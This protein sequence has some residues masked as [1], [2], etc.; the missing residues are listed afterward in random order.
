M[1][2]ILIVDDDESIRMLLSQF[3]KGNG[4]TCEEVENG[5]RA[6]E[7]VLTHE[8]ELVITD[9][10]MP[11]M[12]GIEFLKSL[13]LPSSSHTHPPPVIF[14]TGNWSETL[15]NEA[16]QAGAKAVILKPYDTKELLMAVRTALD[17]KVKIQKHYAS[18]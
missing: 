5:A 1:D 18:I 7:W 4:Y 3:L 6:L 2:P 8:V 10:D 14:M 16:R 11:V 17:N 13:R 12:S 9:N 15:Y